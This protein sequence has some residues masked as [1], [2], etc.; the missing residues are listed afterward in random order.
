[1]MRSKQYLRNLAR[2]ALLLSLTLLIFNTSGCEYKKEYTYLKESIPD[3]IRDICKNEYKMD[4]T[5]RMTG[6]TVWIYIPVEDMVSEPDKKKKPEKFIERFVVEKGTGG[7]IER[8]LKLD[9]LIRTVPET[10]KAQSVVYSKD[11]IQKRIYIW[12][13]ISRIVFSMKP[14]KRDGVE[15][16]SV[17]MADIKNGF[18]VREIYYFLDIKKV[19]YGLISYTEF[20]HRSVQDTQVAPEVIGDKT[21]AAI[22]YRDITMPDF[23]ASQILNRI[24]LKFQKPEVKQNVD[25]DKEVEKIIAVTVKTYDFK[26]FSEAELNNLISNKRIVLNRAA[27]WAKP[28]E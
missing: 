6:S 22:N 21:G 27:I 19:S 11:A 9:Y 10:E 12:Q 25:V 28:T 20:Q 26:D 17:V 15:F 5:T 4:V 23:I 16:F 24:R 2:S 8:R 1:M 14:Q 3:A 13:V 7:F 18:V